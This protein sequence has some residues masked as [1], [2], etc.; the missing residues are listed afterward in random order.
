MNRH[1][2]VVA[3][4]RMGEVSWWRI[5]PPIFLSVEGVWAS[6]H[7]E[8]KTV[9]CR[10]VGRQYPL[11]TLHGVQAWKMDLSKPDSINSTGTN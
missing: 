7:S 3:C 6:N 5:M 8:A 11:H 2:F 1:Y 10:H 4:I 9:F